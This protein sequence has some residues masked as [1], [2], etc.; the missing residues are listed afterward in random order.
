[1]VDID[2]LSGYIAAIGSTTRET[3]SVIGNGLKTIL[4]RITTLGAAETALQGVNISI[5]DMGGN[6]KPVSD[7]LSEL[8]GQWTDLSDEQR[9]NLGV[10]LAGRYQ[11]SRFLALMN[12]WQLSVD[13]TNSSINSQNSSMTEQAKYA[14]SLEGRINKLDTAWNK[15]VLSS[16]E[17][18]VND[19]LIQTIEGLNNLATTT[20]IVVDKVGFLPIVFGTAT[21]AFLLLNSTTRASILQF[22]TLYGSFIRTGDA[23]VIADV[24]TKKFSASLYQ[25]TLASRAA[26]AAMNTL[27][28]VGTGAFAFLRTAALP[29]AGFMALGAAISYVTGKVTEYNQKQQEIKDQLNELKSTYSE[30]ETQIKSLTSQYEELQNKVKSG[31]I[32]ENDEKYLEVQTQ[33][34]ELLPSTISYID[35]KSQA[36]LRSADAIREEL[37]YLEDLT[38]I[39][40]EKYI[41]NFQNQIGDLNDAIDENQAKLAEIADR[42][43]SDYSELMP[44][45]GVREKA[46]L[47][48]ATASVIAQRDINLQLEERKKLFNELAD[49]YAKQYGTSTLLT[50][51]D[52]KYIDTIVERNETMLDSKK[53]IQEVQG[54]VKAYIGAMGEARTATG[55]V[56]DSGELQTFVNTNS[57]AVKLFQDITTE[58]KN[59]NT[60]WDSYES[61]LSSVG[62]K[63]DDLKAVMEYLKN[64]QVE[65]KEV[66]EEATLV[67]DGYGEAVD[68][69][70]DAVEANLST[71]EMLSGVTSSNISSVRE[72]IATY[73]ALSQVENLNSQQK[74]MLSEATENLKGLYPELVDGSKLNVA[75][76][77]NELEANEILLDAT[78]KLMNGE[79]QANDAAVVSK[80]LSTKQKITEMQKEIAAMEVT[81]KAIDALKQHYIDLANSDTSVG[82]LDN[83]EQALAATGNSNSNIS[84]EIASMKSE[85]ESLKNTSAG[86]TSQLR[87]ITDYQSEA[88]KATEESNKTIEESIYITDK[89]KQSLEKLN[90]ELAKIQAKKNDYAQYSKKYQN[91]IKEEIKLLQ[92]QQKLNKQQTADLNAQIK[93]GNI[94]NTGSVQKSS[95]SSSSTYS[96]QYSSYI[97]QAS[98]KYGVDASLIAA[99][100]KQESSFNANAKSS[101]GAMGL[102]QLM[103]GTAKELGVN[104]AYDAYQNIMGGTK[105]ISQLLDK[106][107]GSVTKALYAYNA[108]MG[109]VNNIV[110]S[111]ANEWKGAKSYASKVLSYFEDY[112]GAVQQS[113]A[114]AT[115]AIDG[116]SGT[117][118]STYGTRTRNGKTETHRGID[119]AGNKGDKIGAT[120]AGTVTYAGWGKS[121]TGYGN[122]G[123]VVAVTAA[124]GKTYLYAHLDSTK[125]KKGDKVGVNQTIGTM[126]NTGDSDGVHLHYEVRTNGYGTDINPMSSV[127]AARN[128]TY[129]GSAADQ[130]SAI[131]SAKSEVNQLAQDAISLKDQIEELNMALVESVLAGYDHNKNQWEDDLAQI[132]LIQSSVAE[133]D[134]K[135]ID[136][137][138]KKESIVRKQLEQEQLSIAYLKDQIKH[139]KALTEAQKAQLSDDLLQRTQDMI[140][141]EQQLL[142]ERTQMAD[143]IIDTYKESLEAIKDA[144][145]KQ[146]DEII[147]GI[148]KEADEADYAKQ[149]KDAQTDRQSL[150]DQIAKLALS[151]SPADKAKL[152]ELQ[153]QL[154][155]QDESISDMQTDRAKELRI[156]NLNDQKDDI[157]TDYDNLVNDEK[158]FAQMRSNIINA[159]TKQIEKDL[160]KYYTNIK[161][162]SNLLGKAMSNNLIDLIN[163]ANRYLNGKDYKPIKIASL[164]TGGKTGN[165][166]TK[167]GRLALLHQNET[168]LNE[169]ETEQFERA[170][171][172][173]DS[174]IGQIKN[175]DIGR[176]F[177]DT[178]V[179]ALSNFVIPKLPTLSPSTSSAT[180][181]ATYNINMNID[182]VTGDQNGVK[183]LLN[184]VVNGVRKLGGNI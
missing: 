160:G 140:S 58:I 172:L 174:L 40:A 39:E 3:G 2:E 65:V 19:G 10:T 9:Q 112:G 123:N 182:K 52:T 86:Y 119:I 114:K 29:I 8:A 48:D 100:I 134:K 16:S 36:H 173:A 177:T 47:E 128:G 92:Q 158:K 63:G 23:T 170:A 121:G 107:N 24:K 45:F 94:V 139:N 120:T 26:S 156:E 110:S 12:N 74:A 6:V 135:W 5:R 85:L 179:S 126:G 28:K 136:Q 171:T 95:S 151:S 33:L 4:S 62:I 148:N 141:L 152:A 35:E 17:T 88:E 82:M 175:V 90:L 102:M 41:T 49:A 53:G 167:Q 54:Q 77:K 183:T 106:Y 67:W 99:I 157:Q 21:A 57:T 154:A 161:A 61:K 75:Q 159:N 127:Q 181:G 101:A 93:S 129:S 1:M 34:G 31:V 149:L 80:A 11:L 117:I 69:V 44:F 13:A 98:S 22:G 130:A 113:T 20:A 68:S 15:L 72:M 165:W 37:G 180:S 38:K 56:F 133:T 169:G 142:D 164:D 27:E 81:A 32:S 115:K 42:K 43:S 109:N 83:V 79:L 108:G 176:L 18:F 30:N 96:G 118:T 7:I 64:G 166:G 60:N 66:T 138:L 97:N 162:N 137:Q 163:Q 116:F 70:T 50:A 91:A 14:E 51:E 104:N 122:Y 76:M 59:G 125:V 143:T 147:D 84:S 155:E 73:E 178:A 105:Y 55:G 103:P 145:L 144:Q 78:E 89:H 111:S 184:G 131:D 146:I 132:D 25:L 124:D 168:V 153:K 46:Q 150:L 87:D 71:A